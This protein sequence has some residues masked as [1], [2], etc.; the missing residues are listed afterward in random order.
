MSDIIDMVVKQAGSGSHW[1]SK[2][3]DP[4]EDKTLFQSLGWQRLGPIF[5][6]V[7]VWVHVSLREFKGS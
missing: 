4:P 1:P 7:M 5:Q 3:N 2:K 6:G